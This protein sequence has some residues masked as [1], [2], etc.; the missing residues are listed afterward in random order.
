M[1]LTAGFNSCIFALRTQRRLTLS[2]EAGSICQ[3]QTKNEKWL[4]GGGHVVQYNNKNIQNCMY[5]A[6]QI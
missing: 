4:T 1:F 2:H 6:R 3:K 5:E